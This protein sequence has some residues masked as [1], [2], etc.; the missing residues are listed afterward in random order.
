M[1]R[2]Q[3]FI[4]RLLKK[5]SYRYFVCVCVCVRLC[6]D[7]RVGDRM[8]AWMDGCVIGLHTYECMNVGLSVNEGLFLLMRV[9][10]NK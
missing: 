7:V 10:M 8:A 6:L 2:A 5:I 9:C 4:T 1:Y 3:Y